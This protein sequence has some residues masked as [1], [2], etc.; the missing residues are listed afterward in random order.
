MLT[1]SAVMFNSSARSGDTEPKLSIVIPTQNRRNVLARAVR[2]ILDVPRPDIELLVVDDGS[3]DGSDADL[4]QW[5]TQDKRLKWL[6]LQPAAGANKARNI[7]ASLARSDLLA[8]LDAD[9]AFLTG[10]IDR[11]VGFFDAHPEVDAT[12]D[13]FVAIHWMQDRVHRLPNGY[14]TQECIRDLLLAHALPLTN[15][16]L[17]V[18]RRAFNAVGGFD[19]SLTR[20]QDRDILLRLATNHTVACG[21]ATDVTKYRER[22]SMSHAFDGYVCGLDALVE[23]HPELLASHHSDLLAYLTVRGTIKAIIQGAWPSAAREIMALRQAKNLPRGFLA[24]LLRYRAGRRI[25][26]A[27]LF[28]R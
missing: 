27:K 5:S 1:S 17:T 14:L 16:T 25:R 21:A 2:S 12:I 23:R 6:S 28:N 13:G 15:S 22:S 9:D 11:L 19:I 4:A 8:F 24:N 10:R 3:S 26:N 7:G 18:R 20:H